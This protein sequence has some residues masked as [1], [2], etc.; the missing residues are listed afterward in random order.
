MTPH[1]LTLVL[2]PA[3]SL[4]RVLH[5]TRLEDEVGTNRHQRSGACC[6]GNDRTGS[7]GKNIHVLVSKWDSYWWQP[8]G[9]HW[10]CWLGILLSG[11][12]GLTDTPDLPSYLPVLHLS[13]SHAH[14]HDSCV[15]S[16]L[17]LEDL[18]LFF[19]FLAESLSS[20]C[21]ANN[22]QQSQLFLSYFVNIMY[23]SL[24]IKH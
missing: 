1:L 6:A 16:Y 13:L 8:V 10:V 19:L 5:R 14:C 11:S 4:L 21:M 9:S 12:H 22:S 24:C 20:T 18:V 23:I 3:C 7:L 15:A 17:Q 2:T